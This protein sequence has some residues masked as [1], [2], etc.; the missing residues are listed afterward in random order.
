MDVYRKLDEITAVVEGARAMPMSASCVVNRAELLA[1]LDDLRAVLPGELAR[2]IAVLQERDAVVEDGRMEAARLL[3]EA[4]AE[5]ARMVSRS[6][7]MREATREARRLL[8]EAREDADR[9]RAAVDDYVD[10]KLAN[11]EV[12]L[13]KTLAAVERGRAKLVGDHEPGVFT[14]S[15]GRS[16]GFDGLNPD[17]TG[18]PLPR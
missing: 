15:G 17:G 4:V 3:D 16:D 2:A 8:A 6:E 12:V 10:A 11:F 9:T 13:Q 14:G 5:R 7:V 1:L 18:D